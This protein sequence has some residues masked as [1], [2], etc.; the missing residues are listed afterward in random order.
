MTPKFLSN[1]VI[2]CFKRRYPEQITI[3][4][5][6]Q[7]LAPHNF[8]LATPLIA[9]VMTTFCFHVFFARIEAWIFSLFNT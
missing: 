5:L 6:T 3:N 8:G 2:L 7:H 9:D 1:L 4:P